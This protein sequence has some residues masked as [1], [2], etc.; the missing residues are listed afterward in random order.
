MV[1]H[2][3]VPEFEEGISALVLLVGNAAARAVVH[4]VSVD[5]DGQIH[6]ARPRSVSKN[7]YL[8]AAGNREPVDPG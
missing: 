6:F 4:I 7:R 3:R 1:V 2:H 8:L 5:D